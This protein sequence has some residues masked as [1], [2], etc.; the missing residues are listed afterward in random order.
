MPNSAKLLIADSEK[1]ANLYYAT[2]FL[3]P[4]PFIFIQVDGTKLLVLSDLELDRAKA[5]AKVTVVLSYTKISADA[6]KRLGT[7]PTMLDVVDEVLKTHKVAQLE[8]P[9]DFGM[10]YADGLRKR[11]YTITAKPEPFFPE[12][13]IKS[14][15]EIAHLTQSLRIT[16]EALACAVELIHHSEVKPDGALWIGGKPLTTELLRKAMHLVMMERD[17]VAQHTIVAG[18]PHGVDPHNEGSGALAA[19]VPIVMDVFPQHA[20][21]R[22]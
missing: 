22:P 20:V 10:M 18:G 6:K 3:A 13:V 17:C 11:G 16:E 7:E 8:V 4:D 2:R 1:N 5:Q 21:S 15:E 9:G 14:E 19:N 12:R